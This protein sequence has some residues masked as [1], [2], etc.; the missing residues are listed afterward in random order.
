MMSLAPS[1]RTS[2]RGRAFTLTPTE[3][4]ISAIARALARA[5]S[6]ADDGAARYS[7]ANRSAGGNAG[8]SGGFIRATRPPSWS[9]R[10]GRSARP[11]QLAQRIGQPKQLLRIS[12]LR[13]NRMKP[14]APRH[15]RN[16]ARHWSARGLRGRRSQPALLGDE[17]VFAGG[18]ERVAH[19]LR[20]GRQTPRRREG[21]CRARNGT[22]ILLSAAIDGKRADSAVQARSAWALLAK[23]PS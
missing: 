23:A 16:R 14:A 11:R 18:L 1:C 8:H 7:K 17:A 21:G 15:G 12:Q 5:A 20:V 4:S 9:I 2:S 22:I 19:L 10:M 3:R 6:I 13:L